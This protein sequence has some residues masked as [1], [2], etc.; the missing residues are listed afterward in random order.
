[1]LVGEPVIGPRVATHRGFHIV[2]VNPN[3]VLSMKPITVLTIDGGGMRGLYAAYVLR[4]LAGRFVTHP[5][6]KSLDIGKGFDLVVGTSTGAILAA[7]IA[8]GIPLNQITALYEEA[9]PNIFTDPIPP[10]N[11][12]LKLSRRAIFYYWLCCH[13]RRP[14]NSNQKLKS[15]LCKIFCGQTFGKL[16]EQ[17]EVGLCVSATKFIDYTPRI[18]KTPHLETKQRD[19]DVLLVDACLASSAAPIYL[20]LVSIKADG[21]KQVYADGGLWANNPVLLGLIEGLA[22]SAPKQPIVIVS[23]GTC[24]PPAGASPPKRLGQGVIDWGAGSLVMKLAMNAQ[25]HAAHHAATLLTEQL[26][27]IGKRV[28]ILRCEESSP[29]PEQADLLQLDSASAEALGLM[30]DLGTKDGHATFRWC[31]SSVGK[32]GKL[33]TEIFERMPEVNISAEQ[34]PDNN[35]DNEGL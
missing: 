16:Y 19:N 10:Y 15:A 9:G 17:R 6:S 18:F 20:P 8:A 2:E 31:Q 12:S 5:E 24:P 35:T 3:Q 34:N 13:R 27:R 22:I 28:H 11:K 30:K 25:G 26:D 23:V 32:N 29:S 1:M 21:L 7:G 4:T 14:G 33:L